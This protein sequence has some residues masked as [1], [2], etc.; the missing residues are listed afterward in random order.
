MTDKMSS[1]EP[2]GPLQV[3][4]I[5]TGDANK[6]DSGTVGTTPKGE[7]NMIVTV[8]NPVV[9]ILVRFGN[10]FLTIL[11]GLIAAEMVTNVIPYTDFGSLVIACAKLSVSGAGVG[12]IK[13]L[14]T[15]FGRLEHKFPLLT[16][17]V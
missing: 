11:S 10:A 13:D 9:A 3:T 6:I 12:L 2:M 7:P 1:A 15:V 16:G 4:V 5:G 17:S 8:I 14:V